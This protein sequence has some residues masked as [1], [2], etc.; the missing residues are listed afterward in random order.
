[1]AQVAESMNA[2]ALAKRATPQVFTIKAIEKHTS[3]STEELAN[4]VECVMGDPEFANMY[5]DVKDSK[6]REII[7]RHCYDYARKDP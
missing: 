5:V 6:M 1:M 3:L 7:L 2:A 4:V